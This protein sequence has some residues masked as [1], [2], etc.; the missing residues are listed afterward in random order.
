MEK[1]HQLIAKGVDVNGK[2][3]CAFCWG[4][5]IVLV[6]IFKFAPLFI[7]REEQLSW[8]QLLLSVIIWNW[9]RRY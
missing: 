9:L 8:K 7:R 3:V 6:I 5:L 4:G 2:S 1:V